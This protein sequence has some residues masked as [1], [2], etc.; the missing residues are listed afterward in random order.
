MIRALLIVANAV[1]AVFLA[2][3]V[4]LVLLEA[5]WVD[6]EPGS[7]RDFFLYGSTGTEIMPLA[8][9]RVLP[10][11][12]PE[13]FQP[14][15]PAAGDWI[16]Q[17]G[18]VRGQPDVNAGLPFGVNVSRY[19][20]KSGAPAPIPFV[21][22]NCA[23]CHTARLARA[24]QSDGVVVLGMANA[25]LD[26]VA[27]GEAVKTSLLDEKRLTVPAIAA[28]YETVMREKLGFSEQLTIRVWLA[29][30]RAALKA[31]LPLRGTPYSGSQLR[32][33][34]YLLSG[35]GRNEPMKETVRFL[36]DQ[37]PFPTGGSSKIPALYHQDRRHWAQFDGSLGD[38]YLR[39]SLAALGVGATLEN[40]RMPGILHTIQDTYT[41]VK[42]LE[43]PR[44]ADVAGADHAIDPVRVRR[45]HDLYMQHCGDCHGW[46]ADDGKSWV[47]G[48]RQG[49]VV[50]VQ[51]L[52]TDPSRVTF[53]FYGDLKQIVYDF[54]PDGHPLKPRLE[55]MRAEP[56]GAR[57]IVN[58]PLESVFSRGP[59]LHNGSVPTLAQLLN[60]QPRP[61]V[62][63]RGAS[64]L[65]RPR[66]E[67]WRPL[68]P[69]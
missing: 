60:L 8:V 41:F 63:F 55:D 29:G 15:G 62:F 64:E 67:S 17:F 50:P 26:L 13:Q 38:P 16:D 61:A 11:L 57:G 69:T 44:Y 40:L 6:K 33:S 27:F 42:D 7:P 59:Y 54:F 5:T 14:A 4:T 47:K 21:G 46:L 36:I 53:R 45:G 48:K 52:G 10:V 68:S 49:D 58:E 25:A 3:V 28:T 19:R 34:E 9:L 31:D 66:S 56:E 12:F 2:A 39:N 32:D 35:P 37:T 22:F 24:G 18:F 20:P 1:A 65:I 23:V 30:A 43:G 51:E